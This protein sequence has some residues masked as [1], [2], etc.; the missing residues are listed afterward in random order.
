MVDFATFRPNLRH[1]QP[2]ALVKRPE[3]V[4]GHITR[5]KELANCFVRRIVCCEQAV[6]VCGTGFRRET[7]DGTVY[8]ERDFLSCE[9]LQL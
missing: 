4:K 9:I 6:F 1:Q 7:S 8:A 2:V 3:V 5:L